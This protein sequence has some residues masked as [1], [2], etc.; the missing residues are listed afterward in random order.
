MGAPRHGKVL[1]AR[2]LPSVSSPQPQ[3][4][5]GVAYRPTR[6]PA[7]DIWAVCGF[8]GW[9]WLVFRA[10]RRVLLSLKVSH[11]R[12]ELLNRIVTLHS[13]AD[14]A[15]RPFE[16]VGAAGRNGGRSES[17]PVSELTYR[18]GPGGEK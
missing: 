3:R 8:A 10:P 2:R 4:L 1:G 11:L 16:L 17:F 7:P 13:L 5:H 6:S 12:V 15:R 14:V 9:S 18:D